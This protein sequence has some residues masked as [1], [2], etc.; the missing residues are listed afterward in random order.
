[1]AL[2]LSFEVARVLGDSVKGCTMVSKQW[3]SQLPILY[4]LKETPESNSITN[5][6]IRLFSFKAFEIN[7]LEM[8]DRSST[9]MDSAVVT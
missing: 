5:S 2:P 7:E 3:G 4:D 1:M 8:I 6:G 9:S